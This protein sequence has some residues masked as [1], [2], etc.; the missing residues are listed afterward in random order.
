MPPRHKLPYQERR[1]GDTIRVAAAFWDDHADR[2]PLDPGQVLATP[3]ARRGRCVVIAS[4]DPGLVP[5][6]A[7]ARFYADP[8]SMDEVPRFLRTSAARVVAAIEG[9][10][11]KHADTTL[12]RR[13][14][15]FALKAHASIDQRRKYTGDAY[16]VHPVAVARL[17][18]Q[19]PG[20]TE[21]MLA[22][23]YLHDVVEDTPATIEQI[24]DAFGVE[25]AR[26]VDELTDKSTPAD[27]NR[28]AR[29]AIDR[30]RLAA[31]SPQAKTIKL[32]DL[33]D[34]SQSI[35]RHD[36]KFAAVY[37][38]EKAQLLDVLAGGA[39]PSLLARARA[40]V[41]D[42]QRQLARRT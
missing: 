1:K 23:A 6:L 35:L 4:D 8:E 38:A 40:L 10:R 25:V 41:R 9:H 19:V 34:N 27:G 21:A 30:A 12:P 39:D 15:S 18:E 36:P 5:L 31:A 29:M 2:S 26:L 20:A 33:I 7:D 11:R 14:L 24:R 28:A 16:I 37:L 32:A 22:A 42:G 17:V 13:A 3:L